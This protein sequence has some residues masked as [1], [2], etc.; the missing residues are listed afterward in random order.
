MWG[1]V[2]FAKY[3]RPPPY[4]LKNGVSIIEYALGINDSCDTGVFVEY[5]HRIIVS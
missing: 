3:H 1:R 2:G 5:E 4:Q